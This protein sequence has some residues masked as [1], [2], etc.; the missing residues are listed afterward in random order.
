MYVNIVDFIIVFT[1]SVSPACDE[2]KCRTLMDELKQKIA[3]LEEVNKIN[4]CVE[5]FLI[6]LR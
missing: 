1:F 3:N 5:I 4:N 6:V 2:N